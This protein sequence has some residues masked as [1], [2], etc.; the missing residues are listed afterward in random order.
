MSVAESH[1]HVLQRPYL[2]CS[3]RRWRLS[4]GEVQVADPSFT[5]DQQC[6]RRPRFLLVH[7]M[8]LGRQG[9]RQL[10]THPLALFS[11]SLDCSRLVQVDA[12][13]RVMEVM[14]KL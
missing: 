7:C 5:S 13:V 4:N 9:P 8:P 6:E 11:A 14:L 1:Q 3:Q 12:L 2:L 10:S